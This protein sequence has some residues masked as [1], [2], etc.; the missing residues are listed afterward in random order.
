MNIEHREEAHEVSVSAANAINTIFENN[1]RRPI[2]FLTSGGSSFDVLGHVVIPAGSKISVGVLDERYS[3]DPTVN[4]FIQFKKTQFF[5][6]SE[7]LFEHILDTSVQEN[8]SLD[9]FSDR[10]E[11]M[12]R[13]WMVENH[14]GVIV[15]TIGMGPD[16]HVSGMMPFP[17][18]SSRFE[19]LFNDGHKL[20][21]GYD[22]G[23]KNQYGERATTT[24]EF[25]RRIHYGIGYIV[26]EN[27]KDAWN[28]VIAEK[29]S[30]AETPARIL[31]E[32]EDVRVFTDL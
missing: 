12:L 32:M 21:I 18:D 23:K 10:Y 29:G 3:I 2:L 19:T 5:Q 25:M 14:N 13:A 11:A 17:E 20:V 31:R 24:L 7:N 16:G 28:R 15:A 8:E 30:L 4:N 6:R 27:K 26:G 9:S 1:K 22:A